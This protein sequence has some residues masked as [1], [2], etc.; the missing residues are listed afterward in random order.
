[1]IFKILHLEDIQIKVI[2]SIRYN[3]YHSSPA[4]GKLVEA[5]S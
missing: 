1:L 4:W 3:D 2:Y 5:I